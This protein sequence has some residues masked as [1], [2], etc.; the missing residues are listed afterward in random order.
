MHRH[1]FLPRYLQ[2]LQKL[3]GMP[4]HQAFTYAAQ[5]VHGRLVLCSEEHLSL[6]PLPSESQQGLETLC[7]DCH[8]CSLA[9][10]ML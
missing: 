9:V 7:G 8:C 6:A 1:V 2:M 3:L 5:P 10:L 4:D